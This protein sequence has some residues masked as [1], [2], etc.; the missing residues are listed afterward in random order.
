ME[1]NQHTAKEILQ[2]MF[3]ATIS[4]GKI[5]DLYEET[6]SNYYYEIGV[7]LLDKKILKN[8]ITIGKIVIESGGFDFNKYKE[9]IA[10][11]LL[12]NIIDCAV[13]LNTNFKKS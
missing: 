9:D 5:V 3:P 7:K 11:E 1:N 2:S 13:Y 12:N 10:K 8:N 6:E 4:D